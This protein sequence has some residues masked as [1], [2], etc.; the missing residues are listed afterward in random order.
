MKCS[1]R[2]NFILFIIV[3]LV[4]ANLFLN[5]F[6]M[7]VL[8]LISW[9]LN[10]I[11][12]RILCVVVA[13]TPDRGGVDGAVGNRQSTR[14]CLPT[15]LEYWDWNGSTTEQLWY[16]N[17]INNFLRTLRVFRDLVSFRGFQGIQTEIVY[18]IIHQ[19][20]DKSVIL[21]NMECNINCFCW[22]N[23]NRM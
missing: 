22:N 4:F 14:Q 21:N 3:C 9:N 17:K 15:H 13:F 18:F 1:S 10:N 16:L 6:L 7:V 11:K 23:Q 8:K 2:D 20:S 12:S 19:V 5:N